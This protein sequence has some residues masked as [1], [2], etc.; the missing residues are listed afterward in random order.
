M[1]QSEHD[2]S[3]LRLEE[4]TQIAPFKQET[5]QSF[6]NEGW[7]EVVTFRPFNPNGSRNDVDILFALSRLPL[8]S[9]DRGNTEYCIAPDGETDEKIFFLLKREKPQQEKI[10]ES[11]IT[12]WTWKTAEPQKSTPTGYGQRPNT[13]EKIDQQRSAELL[14]ELTTLDQ[15]PATFIESLTAGS[16]YR[17]DDPLVASSVRITMPQR[18]VEL[19]VTENT[20]VIH[21]EDSGMPVVKRIFSLTESLPDNASAKVELSAEVLGW[22]GFSPSQND[23]TKPQLNQ[24]GTEISYTLSYGSDSPLATVRTTVPV[25]ERITEVSSPHNIQEIVFAETP[26][27]RV[28]IRRI[29][30]EPPKRIGISFQQAK[31]AEVNGEHDFSPQ[32]E[33]LNIDWFKTHFD[34]LE[35]NEEPLIAPEIAPQAT[36]I[37]LADRVHMVTD[38]GFRRRAYGMLEIEISNLPHMQ[39]PTNIEYKYAFDVNRLPTTNKALIIKTVASRISWDLI[40]YQSFYNA[41]PKNSLDAIKKAC[42]EEF[43]KLERIF[44]YLQEL[45]AEIA[46]YVDEKISTESDI[47]A[48]PESAVIPPVIETG[49]I[50]LVENPHTRKWVVDARESINERVR[51]YPLEYTAE[52]FQDA[53]SKGLKH[54]TKVFRVVRKSDLKVIPTGAIEIEQADVV[55]SDNDISAV[56]VNTEKDTPTR[57]E[58]LKDRENIPKTVRDLLATIDQILSAHPDLHPKVIS[59]L[60][61]YRDLF[62]PETKFSI[63]SITTGSVQRKMQSDWGNTS[64]SKYSDTTENFVKVSAKREGQEATVLLLRGQENSVLQ[65]QDHAA[66]LVWNTLSSIIKN[67]L[68]DV[69]TKDTTFRTL[70]EYLQFVVQNPLGYSLSQDQKQELRKALSFGNNI[71]K[72]GYSEALRETNQ[73]LLTQRE[74]LKAS[75]EQLARQTNQ[76]H[77]LPELVELAQTL[78]YSV[79]VTQADIDRYKGIIEGYKEK[80]K[81]GARIAYKISTP[82]DSSSYKVRVHLIDANGVEP[83]PDKTEHDSVTYFEVPAE[84]AEVKIFLHHPGG[85]LA[86]NPEHSLK[87][88]VQTPSGVLTSTQ[89]ESLANITWELLK[90]SPT[91]ASAIGITGKDVIVTQLTQEA[92]KSSGRI[93]SISFEITKSKNDQTPTINT[94]AKRENGSQPTTVRDLSNTNGSSTEGIRSS[95]QISRLELLK[96]AKEKSLSDLKAEYLQKMDAS[97]KNTLALSI[98]LK[99]AEG[100]ETFRDLFANSIENQIKIL[101]TFLNGTEAKLSLLK[102]DALTELNVQI[103][104]EL[105]RYRTVFSV[106]SSEFA[107]KFADD[108]ESLTFLIESLY[109]HISSHPDKESTDADNQEAVEN[110]IEAAILG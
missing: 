29:V 10:I 64:E 61:I 19:K 60:M 39:D 81:S 38:E 23:H 27:G 63:G 97:E 52:E 71:R 86:K 69:P 49:F 30:Y 13:I 20:P 24:N 55:W 40:Y 28:E 42:P 77:I 57:N 8:I 74:N 73:D 50:I 80:E 96:V 14:A 68:G 25:Q 94:I 79:D 18:T 51:T 67:T 32:I 88:E 22:A 21:F 44:S 70:T 47:V 109:Q 36:G 46:R 89:I 17:N 5:A 75:A 26:V 85:S 59:A 106:A 35:N 54:E 82:N 48:L 31:Y 56:L 11:K 76:Y 101:E 108:E 41:I 103:K 84:T 16:R 66:T 37:V 7:S 9:S 78:L 65:G 58:G 83:E 91:A 90:Q 100:L 62:N 1:S 34:E 95:K 102:D 3:H 110:L 92:N 104:K 15:L 43:E 107:K 105:G 87:I 99:G 53:V 72:V 6:I 12:S 4:L 33:A 98:V 45:K 2:H 93:S